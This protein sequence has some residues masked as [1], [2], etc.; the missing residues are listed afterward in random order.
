MLLK[1]RFLQLGMPPRVVTVPN[2]NSNNYTMNKSDIEHGRVLNTA[3]GA[4]VMNMVL[5]CQI[6]FKHYI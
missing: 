5:R 6:V 2:A 3:A 1:C 4:I